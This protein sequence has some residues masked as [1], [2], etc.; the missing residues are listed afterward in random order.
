MGMA[1]QIAVMNLG[2]LQQFAPPLEIYNRPSNKFVA[3]F[4]GSTRINFLPAEKVGVPAPEGTDGGSVTLAIRPEYIG[5]VQ[6]GAA[7]ATVTA[8]VDLVEPLGATDVIHL[9]WERYD[10]RAIG[11]PGG[12]PRIGENIGLVFPPEHLLFFDDRTEKSVNGSHQA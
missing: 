10:I 2:V 3:G 7:E 12:R 4:V 8:K 6:P 5:F 1:D 11:R 9:S